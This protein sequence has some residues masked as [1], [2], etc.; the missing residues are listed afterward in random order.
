MAADPIFTHEITLGVGAGP[1]DGH[2]VGQASYVYGGWPL[3]LGL[4]AAREQLYYDR[5]VEDGFGNRYSY[6]ED[7]NIVMGV[8]GYN[9]NGLDKRTLAYVG[10]GIDQHQPLDKY[11]KRY[12]G[13]LVNTPP[14]IRGREEFV[15]GTIGYDD[16]GFFPTSYT[17]ETGAYA[18]LTWRH[19]RY[20]DDTQADSVFGVGQAVATVWPSQSHQIV[21][22]GELGWSGGRKDI[23]G[24]FSIGG[25][26]GVGL[27]RGYP[28][29]V[30]TGAYLVAASGGYRFPIWRPFSGFSTSPWVFRQLV[31]TGFF[32]IA[33][34]SSNRLGGDGHWYKSAGGEVHTRTGN[35]GPALIDPGFGV[36]EQLDATKQLDIYLTLAY[37]F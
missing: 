16:R 24:A 11:T 25:L 29:T 6:A 20:Q 34:V 21:L 15:E 10:A 4:L 31:L 19:S 27:P 36:A 17:Y 13:L 5:I 26:T 1:E 9:L 33:K 14:A 23:T 28:T 30:A 32:D 7:Q 35:S 8:A 22:D 37:G 18:D 12:Q 3:D 2:P